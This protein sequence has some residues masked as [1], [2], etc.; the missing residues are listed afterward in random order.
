MN[1]LTLL[2]LIVVTVFLTFIVL[3]YRSDGLSPQTMEKIRLIQKTTPNE[4]IHIVGD[5]VYIL[6]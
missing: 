5:K 6:S 4:E 3:V 1:L 2:K